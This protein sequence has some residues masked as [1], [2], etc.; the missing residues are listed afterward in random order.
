[1]IKAMWWDAFVRPRSAKGDN[2][3]NLIK[4]VFEPSLILLPKEKEIYPPRRGNAMRLNWPDSH[5]QNRILQRL[6]LL[7]G[8]DLSRLGNGERN[9]SRIA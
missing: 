3:F 2:R 8:G 5:T 9:L 4:L 7:P 1:M 6:F